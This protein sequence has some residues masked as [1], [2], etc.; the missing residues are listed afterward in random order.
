MFWNLPQVIFI[1]VETTVLWNRY[2]KCTL[3]AQII[4]VHDYSASVHIITHAL[5]KHWRRINKLWDTWQSSFQTFVK[6]KDQTLVFM[7][8]GSIQS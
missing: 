3:F 5:H 6:R 2:Q 4:T 1:A 8:R 7:L